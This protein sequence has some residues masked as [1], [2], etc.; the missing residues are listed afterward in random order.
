[1]SPWLIQTFFRIL[2]RICNR[3]VSLASC[4]PRCRCSPA[5]SRRGGAQAGKMRGLRGATT[6]VCE[7]LAAVKA[8]GFETTVAQHLDNL[9]V[10]LAVLLE[11]QLTTLIVVLLCS[12]SAVLAAL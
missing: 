12:S 9:G 4:R 10:L 8:Q 5:S 2:P 6:Y 7:T 11:G 1:M 3:Q